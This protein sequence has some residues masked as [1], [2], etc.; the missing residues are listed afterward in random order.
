[1]NTK[2]KMLVT[3]L[4]GVILL[5]A[6]NGESEKVE[7]TAVKAE[8]EDIKELVHDYSVRNVTAK[9][10]SITSEQL[11]VTDNEGNNQVYELP[12]DEF[13]V[14]IAPYINETHSCENHS[15]TGCQGELVNEQFDIYIEDSEGN[16][17]V[18]ET[19]ESQGNGF[20]DLWLPREQMYH[21]KIELEGKTV[22]SEFSTFENDG[23][24]I[25]TMQLI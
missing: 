10:A 25:T 8:A 16:I 11:L 15:L 2:L 7:N 24:C 20:I 22:E 18:D 4:F 5:V 3:T 21:I 1:M 12:E 6:C 13:F 9:S 17:I 19:L 23:T 14:S